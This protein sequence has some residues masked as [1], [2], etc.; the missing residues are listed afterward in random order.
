MM[1]SLYNELYRYFFVVDM[2]NMLNIFIQANKKPG[3]IKKQ[4]TVLFELKLK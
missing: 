1:T 4:K 2:M 3:L